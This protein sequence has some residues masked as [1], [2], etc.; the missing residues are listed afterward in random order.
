MSAKMNKAIIPRH[1][2]LLSLMTHVRKS[3]LKKRSKLVA[4]A[5]EHHEPEQLNN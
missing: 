1:V 3:I 4:G 5:I 2:I